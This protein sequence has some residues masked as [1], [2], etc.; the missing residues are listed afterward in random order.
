MA[1]GK[2]ASLPALQRSSRRLCRCGKS[3]TVSEPRACA[4]CT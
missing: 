3:L 2:Q 4:R 1:A